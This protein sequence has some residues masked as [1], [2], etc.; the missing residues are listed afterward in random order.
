LRCSKCRKHCPEKLNTFKVL[1]LALPQKTSHKKAVWTL[2]ECLDELTKRKSMEDFK[3]E[4][5]STEDRACFTMETS[6]VI[7]KAPDYLA[8]QV[9]RMGCDIIRGANGK[10][11]DCVSRKL[12]DTLEYPE[13]IDLAPWT[14]DLTTQVYE[15]YSVVEHKGIS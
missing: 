5:C 8:L 9:L 11:I 4:D 2:T 1:S 14:K 6:S 10:V 15:L 12:T 7:K 3:C 13:T